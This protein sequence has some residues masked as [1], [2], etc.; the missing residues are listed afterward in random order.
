LIEIKNISSED[1]EIVTILDPLTHGC[2][3][4]SM[5]LPPRVLHPNETEAQLG[6]EPGVMLIVRPASEPDRPRSGFNG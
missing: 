5:E 3:L 2:R 6:Y 4:L 1:I